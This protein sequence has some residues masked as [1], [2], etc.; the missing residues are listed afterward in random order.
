MGALK[1]LLLVVAAAMAWG[2]YQHLAQQQQ[3]QASFDPTELSGEECA[4]VEL[5]ATVEETHQGHPWD[6]DSPPDITFQVGQKWTSVC[7]DT[8]TCVLTLRLPLP[9]KRIELQIWD[10]DGKD[11]ITGDEVKTELIGSGW[12]TIDQPEGT[13]GGARIRAKCID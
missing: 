11:Q 9:S 2:V 12:L 8:L 3:Q 1:Y 7:N 10:R 4:E 5:T 6:S 13:L